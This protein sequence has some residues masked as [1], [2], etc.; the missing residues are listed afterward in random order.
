MMQSK[1]GIL[2][3]VLG[4]LGLLNGQALTGLVRS[5]EG[6]PMEG[7][8]VSAQ[9][10]NTPVTIT[11]VSNASGRYSFP[12]NRLDPGQYALRIRAT[13]YDLEDPGPVAITASK[14]ASA[15]L[16]LHRA[17]DLA[18]QLSNAEWLMSMPGPDDQKSFL[19]NCVNCHRLDFITRSRH[20]SAEFLQVMERMGGYANSATP[21]KPQRRKA[22][23]LLEDRGESRRLARERQAAYMS[24]VNLREGSTW[25]YDLKT[26]P[27]P[28]GKGTQV[29]V[30]EYDLPRKT[31]QPHDVI[32]DSAGIIWY[33]NFGEQEIGKFDPKTNRL[34]EFS[35]PITK[36]GWP[37]GEL[38]LRADRQGKL[39]FGVSFQ[40][41]VA[42]FDPQTETFQTFPLTGEFNK[43]MT[44]VNMA[45]P[46][47]SHVDGKVWLQNNGFAMI[48]RLDPATGKF[49]DFAPFKDAKEGENHN[50]Y[51]VIPDSHNNVYFTD[52]SAEHIG[53]IDAKT[54][55]IRLFPTPTRGS[56]P[57][58]AQMDAEDRLWIGEY[59]GNR[60]AM[61]DTRTEKFQEWEAPTPFSAPY[62]V[63]LDK[64][65]YAWTGS[66]SS[67]RVLRLDPKSGQF[68]EYLMPRFTN[69]RRVFVDNSGPKPVLWIGNNHGASIVKVEP[70]DE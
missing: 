15:D 50:I 23:R 2:W 51:D 41:A 49:E 59:R 5:T 44:Q 34:T 6:G 3:M 39:W 25:K 46:Q 55:Q 20:T 12:R 53:R 1:R 17:K 10:V 62:D 48:H 57:R 45:S 38:G 16:K 61:F 60:I 29:I 13:G 27:R 35:V 8:L 4:T 58:R 36:P 40:A 22:E 19:L 65:G 70:L 24:T 42:R 32:V 69:I 66:M 43:D 68:T 63:T 31:I 47:S 14:T 11:V 26:L 21:L 7:V 56:A 18:S 28:Q 9:R 54:G 30:T 33:S 64:S 52:F 37:L 67:D